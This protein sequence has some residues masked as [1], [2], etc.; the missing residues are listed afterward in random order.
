MEGGKVGDTH[1][2][3][4]ACPR[5]KEGSVGS[6]CSNLVQLVEERRG[7]G[8]EAV[9]VERVDLEQCKKGQGVGCLVD[10]PDEVS[11]SGWEV[12]IRERTCL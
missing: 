9:E 12:M 3:G 1:D 5:K 6:C 8:A 10:G 2:M 11:R 4:L 7:W